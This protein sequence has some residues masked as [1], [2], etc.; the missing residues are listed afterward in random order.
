VFTSLEGFPDAT[1][2][3]DADAAGGAFG[4]FV[5]NTTG[6]IDFFAAQVAD[7]QAQAQ[8]A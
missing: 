7:R 4:M 2:D 3:D 1:H 6:L 8:A 5:D